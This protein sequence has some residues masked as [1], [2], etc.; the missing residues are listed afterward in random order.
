MHLFGRN[1]EH[2][3]QKIVLFDRNRMNQAGADRV[4]VEE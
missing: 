1:N 2:E 3:M 4:P